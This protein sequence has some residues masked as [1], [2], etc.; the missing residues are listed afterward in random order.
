MHCTTDPE[1]D[2]VL[3]VLSPH[4]SHLCQA[5]PATAVNWYVLDRPTACYKTKWYVVVPST[6]LTRVRIQCLSLSPTSKVLGKAYIYNAQGPALRRQRTAEAD[7][8]KTGKQHLL[9]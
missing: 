8:G 5:T 1:P 9:A 4:E 7:Q 2:L 6:D 3:S